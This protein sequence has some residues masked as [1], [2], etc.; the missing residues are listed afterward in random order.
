MSSDTNTVTVIGRLTRGIEL[1]YTSG[2]MAIGKMSIANNYSKKQG[3]AWQDEVNY[4]DITLFGRRAEALSQY[5]TKGTQISVTG[6]LRQD[7]WEQDGQKRSRVGIM[8][9]DIQLLSRAEH[10]AQAS[11]APAGDVNPEDDMPF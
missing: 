4:F 2:G 5:L 9:N 3:D 7:R 10:T 11:P 6:S 1:N 8:A